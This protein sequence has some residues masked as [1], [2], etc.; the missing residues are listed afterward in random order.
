MTRH[1]ILWNCL[2]SIRNE[3]NTAEDFGR[4]QDLGVTHVCV[5][6]WNPYDPA[7][8]KAA[9]IRGIEQMVSQFVR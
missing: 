6:P 3:A 9:K 7:V 8:D 1:D 5:T 4:L 2:L